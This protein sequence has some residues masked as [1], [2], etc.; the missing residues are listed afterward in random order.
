VVGAF[1]W[2]LVLRVVVDHV[3][4]AVERLTELSK[5][6]S[7][8]MVCDNL[9]VHESHDAPVVDSKKRTIFAYAF[10]IR[11]RTTEE[12]TLQAFQWCC[13]RDVLQKLEK[14]SH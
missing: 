1:D 7:T 10:T 6:K 4:N 14:L 5:D 11:G 13:R 9:Q 3:G 2:Q 12:M 8:V